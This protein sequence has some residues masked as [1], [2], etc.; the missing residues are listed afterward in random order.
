MA[1]SNIDEK[2]LQESIARGIPKPMGYTPPNPDVGEMKNEDELFSVKTQDTEPKGNCTKL[3]NKQKGEEYIKT[4]LTKRDFPDRHL[5]YVSKDTHKR[6][7]NF[8]KIVAG[9]GVSLSSYVDSILRNHLDENKELINGLF[10]SH[11][12]FPAP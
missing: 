10:K 6:L 8:V 2:M 12:E 9:E 4:F 3:T 1:K 7:S 11:L 5:V